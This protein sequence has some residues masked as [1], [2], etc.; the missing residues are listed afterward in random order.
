MNN[1]TSDTASVYQPQ[2]DENHNIVWCVDPNWVPQSWDAVPILDDIPKPQPTILRAPIAPAVR[3]PRT[4]SSKRFSCGVCKKMYARRPDANIHAVEAHLRFFRFHCRECDF[5]TSRNYQLTK[6]ISK[7][8]HKPWNLIYSHLVKPHYR[9]TAPGTPN[10]TGAFATP[11]VSATPSSAHDNTFS[12]VTP[13]WC[14]CL[15]H[16]RLINPFSRFSPQ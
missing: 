9:Y 4:K 15:S 10:I 11:S 3:R 6:H 1:T 14:G 2:R 13:Q 8:R 5:K 16:R 12:P 7:T